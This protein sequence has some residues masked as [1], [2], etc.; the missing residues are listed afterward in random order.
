MESLPVSTDLISRKE[1]TPRK[2][3]A[4]NVSSWAGVSMPVL[5]QRMRP[6]PCAV[7]SLPLHFFWWSSLSFFRYYNTGKKQETEEVKPGLLSRFPHSFTAGV[8]YLDPFCHYPGRINALKRYLHPGGFVY[9]AVSASGVPQTRS[10]ALS[11]KKFQGD[12]AFVS[13]FPEALPLSAVRTPVYGRGVS[14]VFA[15]LGVVSDCA[16]FFGDAVWR[17]YRA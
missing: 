5:P 12:D 7:R 11:Q 9:A 16:L 1:S 17:A 6:T 8:D 10:A 14:C 4:P 13:F 15:G 3:P 2:K